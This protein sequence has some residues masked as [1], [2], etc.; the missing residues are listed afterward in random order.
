MAERPRL[1]WAGASVLS[2][3]SLA[4]AL[5]PVLSPFDPLLPV[6]SPLLAPAAPHLLGTNDLGQ[7]LLSRLLFGV[8]TSLIVAGAVAVISAVMSWAVGLTAGFFRA[9]EGPLMALSDLLLALPSLPLYLLVVTLIGPDTRHLVLVLALVSWPAFARIVRGIVIQT[10]SAPYVVAASSLG[11]SGTYIVR[12]H[13]LPSTLD[14][15]PSKLVL[16]VRYAV[17]A[18]ATL[19]FLGLADS[20]S[21]SLGTMLSEA[22][23]DPLLFSRPVWVWL[24]LPPAAAIALL[25]IATAWLST[26]LRDQ[27]DRAVS[28]SPSA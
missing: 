9:A 18:E 15:L 27:R 5:A 19:A 10:R 25:I 7:D 2:V 14:V 28:H 24:V 22:F 1:F 21:V 3:L 4:A 12:H 16:T 11:A 6:A 17:F 20:S 23:S 13:I 26:G 8:R